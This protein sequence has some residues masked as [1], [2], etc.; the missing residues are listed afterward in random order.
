LIN[1]YQVQLTDAGRNDALASLQKYISDQAVWVP[2][3]T[4]EED[5]VTTAGLHG[6]QLSKLGYLVLNQAQLS[7]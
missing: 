5:I 4:P 7:Q 2:L 3:W 1:A 6:A